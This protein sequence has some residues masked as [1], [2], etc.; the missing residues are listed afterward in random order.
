MK[1]LLVESRGNFELNRVSWTLVACAVTVG[2]GSLAAYIHVQL[3]SGVS[4]PIQLERNRQHPKM[5][6]DVVS[7]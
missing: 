1:S 2:V 4:W 5:S 3:A 6:R 7:W